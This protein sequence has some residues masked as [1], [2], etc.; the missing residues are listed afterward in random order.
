MEETANRL[1]ANANAAAMASP[2][3]Q[4]ICFQP[5][6]GFNPASGQ[7]IN[8]SQEEMADPSTNPI[9]AHGSSR[10]NRPPKSKRIRRTP[11]GLLGLSLRQL[12]MARAH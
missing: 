2:A 5:E 12:N 9:P 11:R 6:P 4:L 8:F 3:Q 10:S 1:V 7:E